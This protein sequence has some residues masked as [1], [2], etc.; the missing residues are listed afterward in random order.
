MEAAPAAGHQDGA[1]GKGSQG[2]LKPEEDSSWRRTEQ[3]A[4]DIREACAPQLRPQASQ[5]RRVF[6]KL[7]L[8]ST[9]ALCPHGP[10]HVSG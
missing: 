5:L 9:Y 4:Q 6:C 7:L 2:S 10:L 3:Y 1:A 8:V